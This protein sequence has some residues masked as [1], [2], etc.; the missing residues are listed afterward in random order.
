MWLNGFLKMR[1]LEKFGFKIKIAEMARFTR[2][3]QWDLKIVN[4]KSGFGYT[5]LHSDSTRHGQ[6]G[7]HR[8]YRIITGIGF[9]YYT[10][11]LLV[12]PTGYWRVALGLFKDCTLTSI[13]GL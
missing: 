1:I 4:L 2:N 10:H 9:D 5:G 8:D 11:G 7:I 6:R 13:K 12:H 3:M